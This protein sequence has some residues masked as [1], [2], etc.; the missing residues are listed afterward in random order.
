VA[1]S[2]DGRSLATV[3]N[4]QTMILWDTTDPEQTRRLSRYSAHA[5]AVLAVAFSPSGHTMATGGGD[6]IVILRDITKL[7][8]LRDHAVDRACQRAGRGLN[9]DEWAHYISGLPYEQT[10]P[11]Q[12]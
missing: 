2:P 12:S 6:N 4:D 1:F 11:Q 9:R 7:N 5:D 8:D 3:S 10:C